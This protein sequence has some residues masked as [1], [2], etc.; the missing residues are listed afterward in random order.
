MTPQEDF[1]NG[2]VQAWS[3][4]TKLLIDCLIE[5]KTAMVYGDGDGRGSM[6]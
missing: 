1:N 6:V 3:H 5:A 4:E 2:D